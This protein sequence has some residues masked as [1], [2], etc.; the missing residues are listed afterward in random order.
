MTSHVAVKPI[1]SPPA[2]EMLLKAALS[3]VCA[4]PGGLRINLD[5]CT[6]IA[7]ASA[8]TRMSDDDALFFSARRRAYELAETGRFKN[9]SNVANALQAEGFIYSAIRRLDVD[10]LAVMMISRCCDQARA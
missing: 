8:N 9:W 7:R 1:R 10:P 3:L 6:T 2:P 4:M 5:L